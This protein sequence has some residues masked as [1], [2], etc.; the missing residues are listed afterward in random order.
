MTEREFTAVSR[1]EA[2]LNNYSSGSSKEFKS[3]LRVILDMARRPDIR[4][5]LLSD[6]FLEKLAAKLMVTRIE[7]PASPMFKPGP[8]EPPKGPTCT[9]TKDKP[10]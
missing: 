10:D 5:L 1:L 2:W 7:V 4:E 6:E 8:W 9:I 3:D